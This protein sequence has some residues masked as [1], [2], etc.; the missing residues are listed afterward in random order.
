MNT[1]YKIDYNLFSA[2]EI[3][4]IVEFFNL[5]EQTKV[6]RVSKE[7]LIEKYHEYQN[8]LRSKTLEKQYDKMLF[9]KSKV[10]IYHTMKAIMDSPH[11]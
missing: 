5:I 7:L 8:I 2:F 10:S 3:I 11:H 4:K 6:K 9:E 1:E